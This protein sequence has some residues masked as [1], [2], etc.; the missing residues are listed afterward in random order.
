MH[1]APSLS[2]D[3][4]MSCSS[5]L[6]EHTHTRS[7]QQTLPE[8]KGIYSLHCWTPAIRIVHAQAYI[9]FSSNY[10]YKIALA[11][12]LEIAN[13]FSV[14]QFVT[15]DYFA[16]PFFRVHKTSCKHHV[17]STRNPNFLQRLQWQQPPLLQYVQSGGS[18]IEST[19]RWKVNTMAWPTVALKSTKEENR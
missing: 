5:S 15:F 11:F 10:R 14:A 17:F 13:A 12:S 16:F 8:S 7:K 2:N 3:C 6:H 1:A 4:V 19:V 18:N 9:F